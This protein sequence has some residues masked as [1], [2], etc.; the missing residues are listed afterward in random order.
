MGRT[1]V[2][3]ACLERGSGRVWAC[4]LEISSGVRGPSH[5]AFTPFGELGLFPGAWGAPN[6]GNADGAEGIFG[7][8]GRVWT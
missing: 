7:D 8:A 6:K 2:G 5:Q 1:L 3:R 4:W